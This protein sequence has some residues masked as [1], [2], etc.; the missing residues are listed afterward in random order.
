[1]FIVYCLCLYC[2][3]LEQQTLDNSC[4]AWIYQFIV[5][6]AGRFKTKGQVMTFL[7]YHCLAEGGRAETD[8]KWEDSFSCKKEL[9]L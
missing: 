4:S 8:I 5:F 9:I 2:T 6:E 3:V 7:H 1:M